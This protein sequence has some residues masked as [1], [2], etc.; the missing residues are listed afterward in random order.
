MKDTIIKIFWGII[1]IS[2]GGLSLA[3]KLGYVNMESINARTWT[4]V[5]VGLSLAFFLSY[6]LSGVRKWG[7]L[8]PALIFAAL[9]FTI[10]TIL[11]NP[12]TPIIATT[13]LLSV[14]LPFYVGYL[15]NRKH[16]ALL[17]PA[18][19]LTVVA[20]IPVLSERIDSNLAGAFFLYANAL[21][22][23][24]VSWSTA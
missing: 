1:L 16:W 17:I 23:L 3:D 8:F 14:G 21:P 13:I 7:W 11:G 12:D 5:F 15:V 9:A 19:I 22:F 24:V 10:S 18:W 4:V 6:F 2:L 20:F